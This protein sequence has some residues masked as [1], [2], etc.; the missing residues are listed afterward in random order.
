MR[1]GIDASLF[2]NS[3]K[4]GIPTAVENVLKS[5]SKNHP[6]NEYYLF[7]RKKIY[8]DAELKENWHLIRNPI[9]AD[10]ENKIN[11]KLLALPF[12]LLMLLTLT[13]FF[14]YENRVKRA[15][16]RDAKENAPAPSVLGDDAD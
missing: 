3:S 1:I 16:K 2:K 13:R 12:A 4:T 15:E 8:L 7:S 9:A 11:N 5:W 14:S 6:E 10:R